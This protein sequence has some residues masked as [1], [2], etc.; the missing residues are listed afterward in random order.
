M[1]KVSWAISHN[2]SPCPLAGKEPEKDRA[3]RL[4]YPDLSKSLKY[5]V[6]ST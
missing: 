3:N 5:V 1:H 4:T 2:S 6:T